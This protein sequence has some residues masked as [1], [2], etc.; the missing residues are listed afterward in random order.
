MI[1]V[2]DNREVNCAGEMHIEL[3]ERLA[4]NLRAVH[5]TQLAWAY[6]RNARVISWAAR[7]IGEVKHEGRWTFRLWQLGLE[8]FVLKAK[9]RETQAMVDSCRPVI[10]QEY[11]S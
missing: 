8:S 5:E 11:R 3:A 7:R 6:E 2:V 4:D 9:E 10:F 1:E